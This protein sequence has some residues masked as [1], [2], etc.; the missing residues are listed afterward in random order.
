MSGG[1]PFGGRP[2]EGP[3]GGTDIIEIGCRMIV[4]LGVV[5]MFAGVVGLL[6][7]IFWG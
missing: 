6:V 3:F 1:S 7:S 4:G 5:V 2:G